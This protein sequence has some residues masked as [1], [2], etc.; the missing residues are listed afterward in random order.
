MMGFYARSVPRG[1]EIDLLRIPKTNHYPDGRSRFA[2]KNTVIL[3]IA[4]D[5]MK[6]NQLIDLGDR[7]MTRPG[8]TSISGS[9]VLDATDARHNV[10]PGDGS[11]NGP[12]RMPLTLSVNG[13]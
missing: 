9:S 4:R 8:E 2:E 5:G 10:S 11:F 1:M 7:G 6:L 12:L 3:A 13:A